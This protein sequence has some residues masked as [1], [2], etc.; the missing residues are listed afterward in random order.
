MPG[1]IRKL[2]ANR[3]LLK[4]LI[5]R[6]LKHRYVGSVGG[7][8][9]SVIHPV[10]LLVSYTFVYSVI[11][12][13]KLGRDAGTTSFAI[14]VLCGLLPWTLFTD[15]LLRNCS[16]ISDNAPLITKTVI[17][18]EIL[19]ISIT[20]S[21]LVHHLIGLAI[22]L[23]VMVIFYTVHASAGW[24]LLYM[25]ILIFFAQGLGWIV[26][27][28]HVFLR[29]TIQALQI[30]LTLWFFFT[31]ILY[32]MSLVERAPKAVQF[33]AQLNPMTVIVTGYRNSLLNQTQPSGLQIAVVLAISFA[34]F[35]LGAVLFRQAKPAF[36]DIL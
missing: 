14:F 10:V 6:D 17:P 11:F 8:L 32:P 29:D 16:A 25:V 20:I 28:L 34:V 22:L 7:F 23:M 19:P 5:L 30:G 1:L 26:A 9:W 35:V 2:I 27:G 4:N 18:A 12:Q 24:V 31:P 3:N 36:A 21:N 33:V 13:F 15:T